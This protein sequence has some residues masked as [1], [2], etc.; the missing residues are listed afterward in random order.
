MGN[1]MAYNSDQLNE[2]VSSLARASGS[3]GDASGVAG[4]QF[5][6]LDTFFGSGSGEIAKQLGS[7][8]TS[9]GNVQGIVQRQS[10]EMFNLDSALASVASA[11][12]VPTDFVK[13]EQNRYTTYHN[14]I[15]QKL[16]GKSVNDGS[17]TNVD[18]TLDGSGIKE[19]KSMGDITSALET[20]EEVYDDRSVIGSEE[21]MGNIHHAGGEETQDYDARSGIASAEEMVNV[22]RAGGDKEQSYDERSA[23]NTQQAMSNIVTGG[24]M[25][26]GEYDGSSLINT[27]EAMSNM[28][29]SGGMSVQELRD[30]SRINAKEALNNFNG[31]GGTEMQKLREATGALAGLRDISNGGAGKAQGAGPSALDMLRN[32][33]KEG[34]AGIGRAEASA[35]I[36]NAAS[37]RANAVPSVAGIGTG[38]VTKSFNAEAGKV[39]DD[40]KN[41]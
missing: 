34:T 25:A 24:G 28:T 13:N 40:L 21:A 38:E 27:Q 29:K 33:F 26:Q 20:R 8:Q 15:L 30:R 37:A 41:I 10:G 3:A 16:D 17:E 6:G 39:L 5:D 18:G 36:S 12:E 23:I 22:N 9:L 2:T 11:I 7:L 19:Q 4:G 31:Q 35:Q 1:N 14:E 32:D